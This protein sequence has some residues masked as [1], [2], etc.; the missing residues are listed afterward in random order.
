MPCQPKL[1]FNSE[2]RGL[3]REPCS[4]DKNQFQAGGGAKFAGRKHTPNTRFACGFKGFK[5]ISSKGFKS[6]YI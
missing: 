6:L 4:L 1:V 2:N 5:R 3:V